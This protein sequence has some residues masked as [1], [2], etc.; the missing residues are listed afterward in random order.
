LRLTTKGEA[1]DNKLNGKLMGMIKAAKLDG[2]IGKSK[3]FNDFHEEYESVAVVGLGRDGAAYNLVEGIDQGMEN[4]RIAAGK[5]ALELREVGCN[6]I[7][8]D[9][10]EYA[11]QAAE[12]C[13]LALWR[14]QENLMAHKCIETPKLELFESDDVDGWQRGLCKANAQ[15]FVRTMCD[16][17]ANQVTPANFA[18]AA[19]DACCPCGVN[20]DVRQVEWIQNQNMTSFLAVA[21]SSCEPPVF[22]ELNY[23]GDQ[24]DE[25]PILL[26]GSGLTFNTGGLCIKPT[27]SMA[28]YRGAMA[29]AACVVATMRAIAELGLPINVAA[30][31]PLCENM[32]SGM[33]FRPGDIITTLNGKFIAVDVSGRSFE[34]SS[35]LVCFSIRTRTTLAV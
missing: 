28:E 4:V 21:Q 8:V 11:E 27:Q 29:G 19:V 9:P 33:S 22:L 35:S 14:F 34:F 24:R 7:F 12:G 17:P 5:A 18:Q 23:C 10:M 20:V 25:K 13:S 3:V 15:N 2:R 31:V 30:V 32:P 26:V 1:F 6:N 16:S